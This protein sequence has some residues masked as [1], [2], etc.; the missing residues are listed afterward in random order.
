ME[1]LKV[2]GKIMTE[3]KKWEVRDING[4]SPVQGPNT[5]HKVLF[6]TVMCQKNAHGVTS[7]AVTLTVHEACSCH[8]RRLRPA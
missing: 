2:K 6:V 3:D 8:N 1:K 7:A 5:L 4:T